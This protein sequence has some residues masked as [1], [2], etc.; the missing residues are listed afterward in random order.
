MRQRTIEV[1]KKPSSDAWFF[2]GVRDWIE[3]LDFNVH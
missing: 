2:A 3:T 1:N